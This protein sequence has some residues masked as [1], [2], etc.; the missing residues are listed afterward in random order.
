MPIAAAGPVLTYVRKTSFSNTAHRT[1][2]R[3]IILFGQNVASYKFARDNVQ[4]ENLLLPPI[5]ALM[6]G[7]IAAVF[8]EFYSAGVCLGM[9]LRGHFQ[10]NRLGVG[11]NF[12]AAHLEAYMPA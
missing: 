9:S 3:A 7:H 11:Q 4:V 2:W 10:G 1:F 12:H 6:H 5:G 8:P